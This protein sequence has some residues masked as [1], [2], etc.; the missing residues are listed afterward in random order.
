MSLV[1]AAIMVE[2]HVISVPGR[3][4]LSGEHSDWAADY[5]LQNSSLPRGSALVVGLN[6]CLTANASPHPTRLSLSSLL[7]G[8]LDISVHDGLSV[9][10]DAAHPWRFAAA[11]AHLMHSRFHRAA[12]LTLRIVRSTL[13][14]GKGF[15]SSAAVCVL[16]ARAF[17]RVYHLGLSISA[18][19]DIA[20]T[21]ER[22][23]GSPCGRMDQIVAIGPARIARMHFGG[24]LVEFDLV[25]L[26]SAS[27]TLADSCHIVVADLGRRKD[28]A[29]ILKSLQK[30]YPEALGEDA[31]ALRHYLGKRNQLYVTEMQGALQDGDPIALGKLMTMAQAEF[32]AAA[33]PL[34]PEQLTAPHLHS[35]L[36]D[37]DVSPLV[38][39][40]KGGMFCG[41]PLCLDLPRIYR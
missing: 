31:H 12:G 5:R 4:C 28:T 8:A 6:Q 33:T 18:E 29:L 1:S 24:E 2:E 9:A 7:A 10:R 32:D 39:G 36:N 3:L 41:H 15:S 17:N 40:G 35:I 37:D 13:P 25:H 21:A 30:A 11:A 26:P 27:A 20:F 38:Y 19:M 16:V 23:T 34:C 14:E 22:I